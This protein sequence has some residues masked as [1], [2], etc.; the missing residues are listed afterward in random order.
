MAAPQKSS[1]LKE[2][3]II[4]VAFAIFGVLTIIAIL[5]AAWAFGMIWPAR[6]QQSL[7]NTAVGQ[8]GM[9]QMPSTALTLAVAFA[10]FAA[11]VCALWAAGYIT[12]PLPGWMKNL[13]P[14]VLAFIFI[15]RGLLTYIPLGPLQNSTEP[16]RTL[17][18]LY[19]APLCLLPGAGFI[20]IILSSLR[21]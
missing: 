2:T 17:D 20:A 15:A 19:L 12:L 21:G 11:G 13:S 3:G 8:P 18:Q 1:E 16:F 7:V 9:T 4:F 6:D 10:I 14:Y 5:H